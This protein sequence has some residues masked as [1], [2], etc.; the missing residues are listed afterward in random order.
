M[1]R[2]KGLRAMPESQIHMTILVK[3][4]GLVS[5]MPMCA[6]GVGSATLDLKTNETKALMKTPDKSRRTLN[7][8]MHIGANTV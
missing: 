6:G 2:R 1:D 8:I 4:V 5:I 3:D 7:S